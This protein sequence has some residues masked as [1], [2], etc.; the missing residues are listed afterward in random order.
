VLMCRNAPSASAAAINRWVGEQTN[1]KVT[2]IVPEDAVNDLT[3]LIL[4]NAV[5]FKGDW[6]DKFNPRDTEDADFHVS[7]SQRVKIKMMF[8][9]DD[10]LLYGVNH[11]LQCQAVEL[12]YAG[13]TLSMVILLPDQT[14][15]NLFEVEKKLTIEDL[16]NVTEKFEMSWM[17]VNL[18]L[19]RF[20]LDEKLSLLE[21]FSTMG[22][23]HLYL[24]LCCLTRSSSCNSCCKLLQLSLL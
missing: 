12:P 7:P 16:V 9:E 22:V 6:L 2:E 18:W 19:P 17:E 20:H 8:R 5:Y 1:G 13:K 14:A 10:N 21:T 3:R 24:P 23:C 4:V 11:K 15:T